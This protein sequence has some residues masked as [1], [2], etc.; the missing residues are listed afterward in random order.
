LVAYVLGF[1]GN[2]WEVFAIR[3]WFVAC[4]AWTL[5]LPGNDIALPSLGVV[6]G[7]ASLAGVP[8]SIAVA[9]LAVRYR[10]STVIV[11][12]CLISTTVC[13][14]LA[15]TAGGNIYGVLV[16][17]VLLQVTSFADVGALAGGA[18]VATN[19]AERGRALGL[20]AMT[21]FASGFLGPVVVGSVLEQFGGTESSVAWTGAFMVMGLGSV[22]AGWAAWSARRND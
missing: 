19:P 10:R 2:T 22:I 5:R 8:V 3:V 11:V 17:L 18:V 14:G 6:A 15:L 1:A 16:L 20:Y 4:L 21:G 9:E 12:T 13:L 7:L